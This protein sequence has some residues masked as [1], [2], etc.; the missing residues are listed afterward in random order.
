MPNKDK[1]KLSKMARQLK[2]YYLLKESFIYKREEL[3]LKIGITNRRMIQRDIK[4]LRDSR[5][6]DPQYDRKEERYYTYYYKDTSLDKIPESPRKAHLVRLQRLGTLIDEFSELSRGY[7]IDEC[8]KEYEEELNKYK[9]K[10]LWIEEHPEISR[11]EREKKLEELR[12]AKENVNEYADDYVAD[13]DLIGKYNE[14]FS[15]SNERTR[16]RDF[17]EINSIPGFHLY[18]DKRLK[19]HIFY[20]DEDIF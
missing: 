17:K 18:Y 19:K 12:D 8:I 3:M 10:K 13:L 7:C 20:V 4:D 16:Q 5:L 11:K 2:I 14:L 6:I 1:N 15:N 9:E